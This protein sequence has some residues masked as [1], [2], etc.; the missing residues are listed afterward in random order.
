MTDNA[1]DEKEPE[2]F[3][4]PGNAERPHQTLWVYTVTMSKR[5]LCQSTSQRT[6]KSL[7]DLE[8]A[9][10]HD[11]VVFYIGTDPTKISTVRSIINNTPALQSFKVSEPLVPLISKKKQ[12]KVAVEYFA[13]ATGP[14][15]NPFN[16]FLMEDQQGD[17]AVD[18][19]PI[20]SRL[21]GLTGRLKPNGPTDGDDDRACYLRRENSEG[22]LM[23]RRCGIKDEDRASCPVF[24][25][26]KADLIIPLAPRDASWRYDDLGSFFVGTP[27]SSPIGLH[28]SSLLLTFFER[29]WRRGALAVG[30]MEGNRTG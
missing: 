8:L 24:K 30:G 9:Q 22:I 2:F 14:K 3:Y 17:T 23:P 1:P 4:K 20:S 16:V 12:N 21:T 28:S 27:A 19:M 29:Q 18:L 13:F 15:A 25:S 7:P 10:P 5:G 6:L 11:G 26:F